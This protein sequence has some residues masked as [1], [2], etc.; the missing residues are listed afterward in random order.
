VLDG[1]NDI[2]RA[3]YLTAQSAVNVSL[4]T[5]KGLWGDSAGDTLY[6]IEDLTGSP[7]DDQL[8]GDGNVNVLAGANGND[9]L[10]GGGGADELDGG[11]DI[12]T[13]AYG[14]S[15]FGVKILLTSGEGHGYGGDAEGD[16]LISIENLSGSYEDD[17]FIG[18]DD[19]NV[20]EGWAATTR[21]RASGAPIR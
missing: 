19:A 16:T 7:F 4:E 10:K 21:S 20:L 1:G 8:V 14:D 17:T 18:N 12:D 13:A 2:D 9:Y 15:A 11:V 5:G 6:D 3:S